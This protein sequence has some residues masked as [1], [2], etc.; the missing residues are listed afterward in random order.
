LSEAAGLALARRTG[1]PYSAFL[2]LARH[3]RRLL[4][5]G[6]ESPQVAEPAAEPALVEHELVPFVPS[7]RP[8]RHSLATEGSRPS[9]ARELERS[10]EFTLPLET[11]SAGPFG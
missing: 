2:A 9:S 7:S 11:E 8:A 4:A 1:I 6:R 3:A 5:A 10:D